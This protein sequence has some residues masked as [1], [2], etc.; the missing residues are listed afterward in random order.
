MRRTIIMIAATA[1]G[2][3]ALL[4]FKTTSLHPPAGLAQAPPS[5][6]TAEPRSRAGARTLTGP[7]VQTLFGTVQV[8]VSL[9]NGRITAVQALQLPH[10]FALSQQISAYAGPLLRAEALRAQSARIDVVSGATYTSD[11]YRQ[12][13]QAALDAA[14]G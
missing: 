11:G 5:P 3:I 2:L 6:A 12:S 7:A 4:S 1:A 14:H 9:T 8:K 13:L 10:D